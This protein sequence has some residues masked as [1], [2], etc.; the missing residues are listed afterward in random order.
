M[1][2]AVA[3]WD[4]C[5]DRKDSDFCHKKLSP[6]L[7]PAT[8]NANNNGRLPDGSPRECSPSETMKGSDAVLRFATC[9]TFDEVTMLVTN[10]DQNNFGP[11]DQFEK[12][13]HSFA[14]EEDHGGHTALGC[15]EILANAMTYGEDEDEAAENANAV[16]ALATALYNNAGE[17]CDCSSQA[18]ADCPLCSSFIH[19]KSLLYEAMDA[20]QSLDEIDCDAWTDYYKACKPNLLAEYES[21]DLTQKGACKYFVFFSSNFDCSLISVCL[22]VL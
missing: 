5:T 12:C 15:M 16:V 11:L 14:A 6:G 10:Y 3:V 8:A 21:E 22:Y 19:I 7:T 17:F 18:S 2:A 13:A 9:T 4:R 20:C 1:F